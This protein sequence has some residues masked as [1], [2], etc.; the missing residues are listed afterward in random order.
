MSFEHKDSTKAA[1]R[2]NAGYNEQ[3]A[4][5]KKKKQKHY[6]GLSSAGPVSN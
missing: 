2:L 6:T 3:T 5:P 1:N 4:G